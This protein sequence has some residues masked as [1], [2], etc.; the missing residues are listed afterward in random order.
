M[1]MRRKLVFIFSEQDSEAVYEILRDTQPQQ[2]QQLIRNDVA[3]L[4]KWGVA[5]VLAALAWSVY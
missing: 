1:A 3:T 4:I 5:I 2:Y